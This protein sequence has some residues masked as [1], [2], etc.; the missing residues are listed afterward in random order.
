MKLP[1][2][3]LKWLGITS[4]EYLDEEL[5]QTAR[6]FR[7]YIERCENRYDD[8]HSLVTDRLQKLETLKP[9]LYGFATVNELI[10]ALRIHASDAL[11][12][13]AEASKKADEAMRMGQTAHIEA[14]KTKQSGYGFINRMEHQVKKLIELFAEV[15]AQ[16][17]KPKPRRPAKKKTKRRKK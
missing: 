7:D 9:E 1:Q 14:L 10:N 6:V 3:L 17:T 13:A 5:T 8:K 11:K 16:L 4:R 2:K 12:K 15:E